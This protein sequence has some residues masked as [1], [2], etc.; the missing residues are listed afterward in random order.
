MSRASKSDSERLYRIRHS[1]AHIM[2][3]AV[4]ERFGSEGSVSFGTGPPIQDGF[5]YDFELPR[6][7]RQDD[8]E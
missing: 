5:Y 7:L 6:T 4:G 8:L 3:Q 2:A 1:A